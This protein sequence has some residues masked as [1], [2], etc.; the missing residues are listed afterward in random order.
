MLHRVILAQLWV[1]TQS[2]EEKDLEGL[3]LIAMSE[4]SGGRSDRNSSCL[5]AD[6]K[7]LL[8]SEGLE[9]GHGLGEKESDS[10]SGPR[11]SAGL[12]SMPQDL[13]ASILKDVAYSSNGKDSPYS[14]GQHVE[15]EINEC[16]DSGLHLK[17]FVR[18][19]WGATITSVVESGSEKMY[20]IK[21][22][23]LS[24]EHARQSQSAVE[25][26]I[27]G[28]DYWPRK[29]PWEGTFR[30]SRIAMRRHGLD[31]WWDSPFAFPEDQIRLHQLFTAGG[32]T[33]SKD[34]TW[35]TQTRAKIFTAQNT[36]PN[37]RKTSSHVLAAARA[38]QLSLINAQ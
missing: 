27:R 35:A 16:F 37:S 26:R 7:Q 8:A 14:V 19:W 28:I 20:M 1:P 31:E 3:W 12:M 33:L 9:R 15:V 23:K 24:A 21:W 5:K 22:D 6:G 38:F 30:L 4:D 10:A 36:F 2:P 13:L 32:R 25:E 11:T 17:S 34:S 29:S 18:G